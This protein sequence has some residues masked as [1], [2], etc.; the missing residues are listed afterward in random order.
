MDICEKHKKII[1]FCSDCLA[2][3]LREFEG[4][5]R[6]DARKQADAEN[7]EREVELGEPNAV[8]EQELD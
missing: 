6:D 7:D 5:I 2:D 4:E 8:P 3:K 1:C